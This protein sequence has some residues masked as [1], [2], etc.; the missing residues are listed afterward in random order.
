MSGTEEKKEKITET[1]T[2]EPEVY[3]D[4]KYGQLSE[5]LVVY[6]SELELTHFRECKPVPFCG[7]MVYPAIV[8]DFEKFS[9]GTACL[10]LNKNETVQG[11]RTSHL[12]YLYLK[13]QDTKEG[14]RWSYNFSNLCEIIFHIKNGL[15]CKKCGK[16]IDYQGPEFTKFLQEVQKYYEQLKKKTV[17][18]QEEKI[19]EETVSTPALVCPD[20]GGT[21]FIEM[22]KIAQN[23]KTKAYSLFIDGLE[24]TSKDFNKLRQ[25]VLYQN[26]SDYVDD[27]WV[28]TSLKKDHEEK[29]RLERQK[30]DVHASIEKKVICLSVTTN[31]KI[32]EIYDMP[33]RQFTLALA[34]VD[35]YT[36][37]K[38]MRQA[39]SSGF[40][41]L[42]KGEKIE[43]WIYKPDKDMY[44]DSYKSVDQIK[45]EVSNL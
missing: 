17:N 19:E 15:K 23:P 24:I 29:M 38:I 39:V 5:D 7:L 14:K 33:I 6:L 44:G 42:K 16:I 40:V 37:Y 21:D 2:L 13:M 35:D 9:A 30:N 43:H 22:I 4:K 34:T 20:C 41:T 12:G 11:I 36:N 1:M 27:S 31:Y 18:S 3:A 25:L 26:F 32:S 8:R 45:N 28:D 10:T